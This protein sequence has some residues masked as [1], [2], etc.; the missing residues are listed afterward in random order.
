MLGRCDGTKYRTPHATRAEM[1][2][3]QRRTAKNASSNTEHRQTH[4]RSAN[5]DVF[6]P[7]LPPVA[8]NRCSTSPDRL[9][10]LDALSFLLEPSLARPSPQYCVYSWSVL[11]FRLSSRCLKMSIY[12]LPSS[13]AKLTILCFSTAS[14]LI[15]GPQ[16]WPV[17]GP[18]I[19]SNGSVSTLRLPPQSLQKCMAKDR[20]SH[21]NA[22][23]ILNAAHRHL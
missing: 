5:N 15:F 9:A 20:R 6:R 18:D 17:P 19:R 1:G 23:L 7:Q 14:M 2:S 16:L 21:R 3:S 11:F 8:V 13:C 4:P 10:M 12:V 22:L